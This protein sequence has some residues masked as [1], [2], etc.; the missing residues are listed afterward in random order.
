MAKT[1]TRV[2]TIKH[3]AVRTAYAAAG[4]TDLA[5]EVA[6][7]YVSEAQK[8]V[9]AV[10]KQVTD[11]KG[12]QA[13]ARTMVETRVQE[14]VKDVKALPSKVESIVTE[15]VTD[16]NDTYADLAKR[17]E[18]LVKKIRTNPATVEAEKAAKTTVSKAK[19]TTTSARKAADATTATA[20]KAVKTSTASVK[21]T[22]AN[23]RSNAKATVTSAKKTAAKTA[24]AVKA[25]A[26]EIG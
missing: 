26:K 6:R 9:D 5:V 21:K 24:D 23:T 10:R 7:G 3:E 17:G 4:A 13:K 19:A 11:P 12:M 16:L 15:T 8:R 22:T 20:E 25:A 18:K 2:E 1:A 14:T